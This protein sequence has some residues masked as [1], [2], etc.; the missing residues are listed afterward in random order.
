MLVVA[1]EQVAADGVNV[2]LLIDRVDDDTWLVDIP[3]AKPKVL[4]S[5][6]KHDMQSPRT[7]AGLL[8]YA[9]QRYPSSALVLALEGHGAQDH[10][11]PRIQLASD[12]SL[13]TAVAYLSHQPERVVGTET[14]GG[15]GDLEQRADESQSRRHGISHAQ[16]ELL[17]LYRW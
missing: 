7:L 17:S 11:G 13:D 12:R 5:R 6:W 2:C 3:A 10:A 15:L 8:R 1:L 9:A 14:V 4:S 16:L